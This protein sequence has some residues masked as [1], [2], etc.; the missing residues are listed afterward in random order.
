MDVLE[1]SIKQTYVE[2]EAV[3]MDLKVVC[4]DNIEMEKKLVYL[5]FLLEG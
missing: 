5:F 1:R 3:Q 4:E 2:T